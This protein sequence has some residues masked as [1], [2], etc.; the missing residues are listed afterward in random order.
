MGEGQGE[1]ETQNPKQASGSKL[2]AQSKQATDSEL[3]AQSPM[4]ALYFPCIDLI[5]RSANVN[6]I[7]FLISNSTWSL[8]P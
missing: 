6:V 4:Q 7:V 2:S 1:K 3:S 5:F 8:L